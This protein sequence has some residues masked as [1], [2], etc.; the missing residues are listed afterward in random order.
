MG[1][2]LCGNLFGEIFALTKILGLI[3]KVPILLSPLAARPLGLVRSPTLHTGVSTDGVFELG[4]FMVCRVEVITRIRFCSP[5]RGA[6]KFLVHFA[7]G[8]LA[9]APQRRYTSPWSEC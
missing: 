5:C 6:T 1:K 8:L 4:M 9:V 3:Q 2:A 7:V